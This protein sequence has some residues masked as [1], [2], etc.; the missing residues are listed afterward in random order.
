M[1]GETDNFVGLINAGSMV[2]LPSPSAQP[3]RSWSRG[4]VQPRLCTQ[5]VAIFKDHAPQQLPHAQEW[6]NQQCQRQ[7]LQRNINHSKHN[8]EY[9]DVVKDTVQN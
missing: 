2:E 1:Y 3:G 7:E 5:H 6:E 9:K 8:S 4:P